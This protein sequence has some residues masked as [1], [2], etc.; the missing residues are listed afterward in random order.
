M[1]GGWKERLEERKVTYT[2]D[3]NGKLIVIE[4]VPARVNVETGEQLF[5]PETV[6]RLQQMIQEDSAPKRIM[7]VPV[8]D[9]D[10]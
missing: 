5:L 9:F 2:L 8:F 7:Q 4:N 1:T 3:V 6:R 10:R